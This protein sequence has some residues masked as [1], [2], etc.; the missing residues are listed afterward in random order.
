MNSRDEDKDGDP[1]TVLPRPVRLAAANRYRA[2]PSLGP[3]ARP[4]LPELLC[5]SSPLSEQPRSHCSCGPLVFLLSGLRL[6]GSQAT[7]EEV[8]HLPG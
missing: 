6:V 3:H 1:G 2:Q 5:D 8:N 7:R 4:A